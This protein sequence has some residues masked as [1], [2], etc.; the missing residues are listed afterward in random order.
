MQLEQLV[1][2]SDTDLCLDS[3]TNYYV[4]KVKNVHRNFSS[5]CCETLY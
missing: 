4:E 5:S 3:V 2:W 1:L